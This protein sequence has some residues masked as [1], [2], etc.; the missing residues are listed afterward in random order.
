MKTPLHRTWISLASKLHPPLPKSTEQSQLVMSLLRTSFD[1]LNEQSDS[2]PQAHSSSNEHYA[3]LHLQSILANPLFNTDSQNPAPPLRQMRDFA[4]CQP[5]DAFKKQVSQGTADLATAK[6]CLLRQ[7]AIYRNTASAVPRDLMQ[8]SGAASII[9]QWLWSSGEEDTGMFLNDSGFVT[10]LIR[11]LVAEGHHARISQWL[12]R[13]NIIGEKPFSSLHGPN[14]AFVQRRLLTRQIESE[15]IFGGGL[16]SA[17]KLFNKA[18]NWQRALGCTRTSTKYYASFAVS[19]LIQKM[20]NKPK[21]VTLESSVTEGFLEIVQYF[22]DSISFAEFCVFVLEP[23]N[24]QP[25]LTF[26]KSLSPTSP[27][28]SYAGGRS[29]VLHL[30]LRAARLFVQDDRKKEL[31]ITMDFMQNNFLRELN[32]PPTPLPLIKKTPLPGFPA[33]QK[34]AR[35]ENENLRLLEAL[36]LA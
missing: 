6:S 33:F 7:Y 21:E 36:A 13:C 15:T 31:R 5:M 1:E 10:I 24:P 17:I 16:E 8:S 3:N 35:T 23:P 29:R 26:L 32:S 25:A 12:S 4:T 22:F 18:V 9:L 28:M 20:G 19:S 27:L 14:K 34:R 2:Q 30:G 11:F